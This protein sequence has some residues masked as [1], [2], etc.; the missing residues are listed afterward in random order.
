MMLAATTQHLVA[1]SPLGFVVAFGA[2]IASFLSPCVLP[3]VPSYLSLMS[4]VGTS[5]LAVATKTD[6][7]RL[8]KATLLFVAGFTL[9]FV[10]FEAGAS[11]IGHTLRNHQ[12]GLNRV[13][14]A[15]ILIMG[16][17]LAGLCADGETEVWDVTH[18]DRGYP[19]FVEN[20]RVLGA[21]IE[22]VTADPVR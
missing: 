20:L 7:R 15:V 4:G 6:Q 18:I 9:V 1:H 16:L 2:G 19:G 5:Q 13:A 3:L 12:D 22:R 14:G 8:L 11:T 21:D 17:V 10:A